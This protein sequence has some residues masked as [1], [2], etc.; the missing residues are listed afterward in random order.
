MSPKMTPKE[1]AV[2]DKFRGVMNDIMANENQSIGTRI[3]K[4]AR[5]KPKEKALFYEDLSWTWQAFNEESNRVAHYFYDL[6]L[7]RGDTVALM[8]ENCP[9]YF[10]FV[11]GINKI[12]G[13]SALI[14]FNQRKQA[15]THSF[16]VAEAKWIVLDG[17]CIPYFNDV[18][19]DLSYNPDQIFVI[20]NPKNIKHEYTDLSDEL[21]SISSANP[22]TTF[23]SVLRETALYIYT[24]GTTGLPKAVIMQNFRLYTQAS[25]LCA[26]A[27]LGP[28]EIIYIPTPLYHNV[29]IGCSWM[30]AN[31]LGAKIALSKR[32]SATKFWDDIRKFQATYFMYV[33]EIPRYLLNQPPSENDKNHTLK[34]MLGLGLRK[35]IWEEFQARFQVPNI[36][37]FYG[38]TEGHRP[39]FNAD[40]VPG[41]VG[42][43]NMAGFS[44]AKVDPDTGE[45]YKNEKGYCI[46]CKAGDIGMGLIKVEERGVFTGYKDKEKTEKK[47]IHNVFRKNDTFFH[48]GDM[49][50]VHKDRWVSFVD[51][52]GDTFRW[53]G[54]NVSTLEVEAILNSFPAI[55]YSAVYGVAIP[56]TEGKAGMAAF[57]LDSSIKFDIDELSQFVLSSLPSYSIP[58]FMR[59]ME[60]LETTTS[61]FK[62]VKTNLRKEIYNLNI[63]KDPIHFWDSSAKKYVPLT[64]ELHQNIKEGK[65]GELRNIVAP[66]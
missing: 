63:V 11:A 14:N 19:D 28:D 61:S 2:W 38:S 17:T 37:E 51:R 66:I 39:L 21:K 46:K 50:K 54:E 42:R 33:G 8:L 40:G 30:K 45:F 3:E 34:K 20:N 13:I 5:E 48:T 60:E 41:M 43:D 15:L 16:N 57:T 62:I 53:K 31:L 58:I 52:F 55:Q 49:L 35:E 27:D 12:Q 23:D 22:K 64:E 59:I 1:A 25:I 6:G 4:N 10:F 24:S 9:E 56:N 44:I 18:V 26:I 65:Y 29:G 36:Y 47:I 32:F 7:Q